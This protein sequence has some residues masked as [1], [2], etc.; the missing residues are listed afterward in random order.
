MSLI[1]RK[2]LLLKTVVKA[3][4]QWICMLFLAANK[5]ARESG[6]RR[7]LITPLQ[8]DCKCENLFCLYCFLQVFGPPMQ[9][10]LLFLIEQLFARLISKA[11]V[12]NNPARC[13]KLKTY[14]NPLL[15]KT[16]AFQIRT[17]QA[18]CLCVC[19]CVLCRKCKRYF[20][21]NLNQP[22]LKYVWKTKP[23]SSL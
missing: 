12:H 13:C 16:L 3:Q 14:L 7:P 4:G 21:A 2:H 20:Q 15:P 18:K 19:V 8:I 9:L 22:V 6:C 23:A 17:I 5:P 10:Y 11:C 1:I